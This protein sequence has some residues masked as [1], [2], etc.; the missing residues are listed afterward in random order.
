MILSPFF[1]TKLLGAPGGPL[2]AI[3]SSPKGSRGASEVRRARGQCPAARAT[4]YSRLRPL[5]ALG[6]TIP[7]RQKSMETNG[8]SLIFIDLH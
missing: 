6:S 3:G 4:V 2:V 7:G 1:C 5:S 8:I